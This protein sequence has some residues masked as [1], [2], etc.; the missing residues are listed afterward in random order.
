MRWVF[1]MLVAW[2]LLS[3]L[4]LARAFADDPELIS[5]V[6][7][8]V[9]LYVEI[10]DL[11]SHLR[12]VP[13]T[14]WFRRLREMPFVKRW[15]Q[16]PEFAKWQV[17]QATL[18]VVIGQPLDQFVSELFGE[19]VVLAIS[20]SKEGPPGGVLLSRAAK[21]D[22]WDRVLALWDQLEAHE[23]Q[24]KSAFGRS[25]QRRQKKTNGQT[26]GP[27]LFTAKIGRILAIS[28]REE[29][30]RDVLARFASNPNE[31]RAKSL[32]QSPE[33]QHAMAALPDQCAVRV[34]VDPR[35]WE[36]E[37]R[38]DSGSAEWLLPLW[39][40]LEWLSAGIELR[41]GIIGHAV[42]HHE[43]TDL[44]AVWQKFVE[45]S[46]TPS[47]LA[48]RLPADAVLAGEARIAPELL[49]WLRTLDDSEKARTDWQTFGKITR[50]LLGRDLFDDVLPHARPSLGGAVVPK[51]PVEERSAP[52]DG[53][54]AW[55]LDLS[56]G[57]AG[58][59][60]QPELRE[61]LDSA[62]LTLLNFAAV[63]HN[64][65]NPDSPATLRV[66][67]REALTIKW[68]DSLPPYRPAFGLGSEHVLLATDPR[69]ISAFHARSAG[70]PSLQSEPLFTAVHSRH[71]AEHSH[72]LFLNSRTAR[73][74]LSEQH[75]P[76]SR[77]VAH[78]RKLAPPSVAA[79]LDRV[80]EFLTPFDAAFLAAK[81][82]PGEVRFTAGAVTPDLRK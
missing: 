79:Q 70:D 11:R 30:I 7:E 33:Y 20:P 45:A 66:Q 18:T 2:P 16:G 58:T 42:V 54:L 61:S 49:N 10:R 65:R 35:R 1:T 26:S 82:T 69:L 27:D 40:R 74:F 9:G 76:L 29:L 41:D 64:S 3:G 55:Q 8:E 28:E 63:A 51:K 38:K 5:L 14:E 48:T 77:Q 15:Q 52:V 24:T 81:V 73:E 32:D 23:V 19:S 75:E 22:T 31:G 37:L 44:P 4:C 72:W 50:G 71:M 34:F 13:S 39:R 12:D 56:R 80:R 59:D 36:D 60:G 6:G 46:A 21:D 57:P 68:L 43:T 25:F 62:L 53:L 17:G 67:H 78:W 47:D